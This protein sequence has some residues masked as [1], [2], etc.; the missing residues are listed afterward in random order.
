VTRR[1]FIPLAAAQ[2]ARAV[3]PGTTLVHEH[4]LVDFI[5]ADQIAPGRYD[6][7]EVVRLAKPKLDAIY[8][9][10]CRRFLEC[11]PNYIG[12]DPVLLK[13]LAG[14][15]GIDIWTNTGLYAAANYKFVPAFARAESAAQLAARWIREFEQGVEG[16]KPRFIKIGVNKGPLGEIDRKFVEAAAICSRET[17]LTIAAHTGDG[18]AALEEL[19]IIG[20]YGLARKFVWVHAQNELDHDVHAK[21]AQAGAWVEFDGINA[22]TASW[23]RQ[24]VEA[25]E[26]RGWLSQT[27]ISQDSGWYSPGEPNGG[28]FRGYDFIYREFLPSLPEAWRG[29]LMRDNPRRAFG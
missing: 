27:L 29:V 18:A 17:G 10:G 20:G 6:R 19:D 15:T 23:H 21:V 9:L 13:R 22:K 14:E 28:D 12:R 4:I 8:K 1:E 25:M 5:G 7:D 2:V 24:C 26:R 3:D 16:V 11:T